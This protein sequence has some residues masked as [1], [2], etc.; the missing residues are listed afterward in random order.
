MCVCVSVCIY[1]YIIYIYIYIYINNSL[2]LVRKYARIFFHGHYLF[3]EGKSFRRAKLKENCELRGT[4]NVQGQVP[5]LL[6]YKLTPHF[7]GQK[8]NFSSFWGKQMK[9]T[10]IQISQNV[11]LF[12]LRMY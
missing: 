1:V 7:H 8:S 2:H 11:D 12:S 5:Y 6:V 9:F 3:R 4:D 10:P